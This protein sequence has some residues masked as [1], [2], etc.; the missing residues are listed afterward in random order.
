MQELRCRYLERK[1][2]VALRRLPV[3]ADALF[4]VL[5]EIMEIQEE[6]ASQLP[7]CSN[8]GTWALV[9]ATRIG[10]PALLLGV[11]CKSA[12]QHKFNWQ[13]IGS[14]SGGTEFPIRL[15]PLRRKT[16]EYWWTRP[17]GIDDYPILNLDMHSN[18]ATDMSL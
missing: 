15:D 2:R 13:D 14:V 17:V 7:V 9:R 18:F 3:S 16:C 6:E 5:V 4:E 12:A 11:W 8:S 1:M 10:Y